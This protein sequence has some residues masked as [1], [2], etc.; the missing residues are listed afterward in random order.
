MK[1]SAHVFAIALL[2]GTA[3]SPAMAEN[4]YAAVDLGQV[5]AKD[6]CSGA[7]VTGCKDN[8]SFLRVAGGYLFTPMFGIEGSYGDYGIANNV[9]AAGNWQLRGFQVSGIGI[10][11][12]GHDFSLTG[13]LGVARTEISD[14]TSYRTP[15]SSNNIA[16]GIGALYDFSK[17]IAVRTQYEDLGTVG[18][19]NTAR[20]SKVTLLT[21]G[22]IF[23]F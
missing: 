9:T 8:A 11:P 15:Y 18:D 5:N 16:I 1:K 19:T 10:V 17:T 22:A 4:F 3:A 14:S 12:L 6:S 23:R 7:T 2:L 13:K 20:T 21:I